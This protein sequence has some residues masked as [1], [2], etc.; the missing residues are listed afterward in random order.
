MSLT[1]SILLCL[2]LAALAGCNPPEKPAETK[3]AGGDDL[4]QAQALVNGSS[5]GAMR[6]TS[7]FE[8]PDGIRGVVVEPAAGGAKQI[9]WSTKNYAIILPSQAI[10]KDGK[11]LNPKYLVQE[12]VYISS[13]QLAD[14]VADRGFIVGKS[15]PLITAF[16]DPNCIF[17]N[18][19]YKEAMPHV[20]KGEL[21]IRFIMVG[22]L[23]PSSIPRAVAIVSAK[24]PAKVL[25]TDEMKFD[26]AHEEGGGDV[27]KDLDADGQKTVADDTAL[28]NK[29]GGTGTPAILSCQKG[30][31]DPVYISG[32]PQDFPGFL[33]QLDPNPS[34]KACK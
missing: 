19:L 25:E 8:G 10:D 18:K 26:E 9:V 21:R 20:N 32:M 28:M 24:N 5:H 17:C 1:R 2:S 13:T 14:Q 6:A 31:S 12:N 23:K 34:H 15:G 33:A 22:F 16:M 3:A 29:A 7:T 4:S 30:V 11:D 27:P